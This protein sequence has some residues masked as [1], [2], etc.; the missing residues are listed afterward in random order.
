MYKL[1]QLE[2][3]PRKKLLLKFEKTKRCEE[4]IDDDKNMQR[5]RLLGVLLFH[6]QWAGMQVFLREL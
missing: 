2:G 1:K 4:Y 3:V 6:I 5:L